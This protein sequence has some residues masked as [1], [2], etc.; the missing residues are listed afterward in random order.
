MLP[1]HEEFGI[2]FLVVVCFCCCLDFV[3]VVLFYFCFLATVFIPPD[4][5]KHLLQLA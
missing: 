2:F 4:S 5:G 3:V 1:G